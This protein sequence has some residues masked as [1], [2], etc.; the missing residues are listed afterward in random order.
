MFYICSEITNILQRP[1]WKASSLSTRVA[2][3]VGMSPAPVSTLASASGL[4][5]PGK[6]G[7]GLHKDM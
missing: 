2:D 4:S 6:H 3:N 7:T 5:S 1:S